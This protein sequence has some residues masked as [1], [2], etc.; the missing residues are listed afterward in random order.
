G[1]VPIAPVQKIISG[2]N[3]ND[4]VTMTVP[5]VPIMPLVTMT[6]QRVGIAGPII[7]VVPFC[8]RQVCRGFGR[9]QLR[10]RRRIVGHDGPL[11][12]YRCQRSIPSSDGTPFTH[13]RQ[14]AKFVLTRR[15]TQR[16]RVL[17]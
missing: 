8:S 14:S 3:E 17:P 9:L 4:R 10:S 11:S 16:D 15:R 12:I 5:P 7:P 13:C 6:A 2:A 1:R